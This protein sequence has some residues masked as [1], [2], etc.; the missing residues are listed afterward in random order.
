MIWQSVLVVVVC[1]LYIYLDFSYIYLFLLL[2]W[3]WCIK[4]IKIGVHNVQVLVYNVC[5]R[6][7]RSQYACVYFASLWVY[8]MDQMIFCYI[9]VSNNFKEF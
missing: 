8:E 1:C 3:F 5:S 2:P 9:S 4:I 6:I 7:W